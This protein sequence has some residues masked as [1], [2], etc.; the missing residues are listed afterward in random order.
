MLARPHL[1][2]P[3]AEQPAL[4]PDE[5]SASSRERSVDPGIDRSMHAVEAY[6]P[7]H[8]ASTANFSSLEDFR[9]SR[10]Q[11][12]NYRNS[13][14]C[15]LRACGTDSSDIRDVCILADLRLAGG[16]RETIQYLE[17]YKRRMAD[18]AEVGVVVMDW[19]VRGKFNG[20]GNEI[21]HYLEMLAIGL[22]TRRVA[23]VQTQLASCPGTTCLIAPHLTS[24]HR[25]A[26]LQPA[27]PPSLISC[28]VL[29]RIH[30]RS[31]MRL[32]ASS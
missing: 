32:T 25:A 16:L 23:F 6:P 4:T 7:A 20:I 31:P 14:K 11:R 15:V 17:E 3:A 26:S 10:K 28:G 12:D 9:L 21:Q 2:P 27:P 1:D 8:I 13:C 30:L 22:S 5:E 18:M 24:L 19:S 29:T